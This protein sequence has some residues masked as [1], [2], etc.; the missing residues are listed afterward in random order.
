MSFHLPSRARKFFHVVTERNPRKYLMF[1]SWYLCAL[2]G[3]R[4]RTLGDA[5]ELETDAFLP[6]YPEDYRLQADF[7]AGL[8]IDA[9]IDRNRVDTERKAD[10]EQQMI[11]LL[12]PSRS[13]GLSDKGSEL[14]NRYAAG[15]FFILE[16]AMTPPANIEDLLVA[17]A[18]LWRSDNAETQA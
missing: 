10:V 11:L 15:G 5:A 17:Y 9:E 6:A 2:L 4:E 13:T 8:L 14:L 12:E 18:G 3:L 16:D 7:I 1:D